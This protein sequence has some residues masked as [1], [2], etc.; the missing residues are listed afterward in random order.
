MN[1][2]DIAGIAHTITFLLTVFGVVA[3][4]DT[5]NVESALATGITA[6]CGLVAQ[7]MVVWKYIHHHKD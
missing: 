7:G 2:A 6:A 4:G 1:K 3:F 5:G